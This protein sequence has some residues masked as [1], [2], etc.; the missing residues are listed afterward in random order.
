[1][2]SNLQMS[3][4]LKEQHIYVLLGILAAMSSAYIT[5]QNKYTMTNTGKTLR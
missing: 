2:Q 3:K 1:M 4:K 5:E